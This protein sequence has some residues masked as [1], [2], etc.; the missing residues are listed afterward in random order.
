M[1]FLHRGL[2]PTVGKVR[3][4]R[5]VAGVTWDSGVVDSVHNDLTHPTEKEEEVEECVAFCLPVVAH[6]RVL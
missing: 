4:L 6:L 2:V 1:S 5:C 3:P